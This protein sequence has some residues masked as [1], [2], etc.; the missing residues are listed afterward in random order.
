MNILL[1]GRNVPCE[2][3]QRYEEVI[4][5]LPGGGKG[6]L[7]VCVGGRAVS[8]N[9]MV[10]DGVCARVLTY[11]DEEG[12]R[13]YE[14][15]IQFV[16]LAAARRVLPGARVRIEHSF[17]QALFVR[18]PGTTV[19]R[20]LVARLEREMRL[21]VEEDL[22][23]RRIETT[24]KEANEY[25]E[26]TG[27][28]DKLRLLRYRNFDKFRFYE[29]DGMYEYFYGEMAPSTRYVSVFALRCYLP[30][31]L[32]RTPDKDNPGNVAPFRDLPKLMRTFGETGRWNGIL[33][34]EN[35]A[36]INEMI[37]KRR[38]REFIRVN[39][40]LH[41]RSIEKI[42]DQFVESGARLILIAGPSSSGKTTFAH[43]LII[44]LKALGLRPMKL[45]LDDYYLDRKD[46]PVGEDGK[47]DLER[48]DTLDVPLL[49]EHLVKL[50][51]GEAVEA[52][53]F[54]FVTGERSSATHTFCVGPDQ[55]IVIEGIHALNEQLT[56]SVPREMKFKVYISALTMLNLDDHNRI[57][58]TDARLLRRIVRDYQF[59]GTSPEETMAMW[60][61]VRNGEENYI[62]PY[63][64]E[65]D[66]MFNSVLAYELPI[67]KK[68]VYPMLCAVPPESECYT[69]ARRLVKFLNYLRTA[70][71]EDE[72]PINSILREFIGGCCFYR[73]ED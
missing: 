63:Q 51:Q 71:V 13:I 45:S 5:S 23:I 41:E 68:Y 33:K 72:I 25:F 19:T 32:L 8:L 15:T 20:A 66:A 49:D 47:Q 69:L 28:M 34:C 61:S 60:P 30:G 22:P 36:D 59:R 26:K 6:A 67:M 48:L 27:Q 56:E 50:L 54:D 7:G 17:G 2:K 11:F 62:F 38:F 58:T 40:A 44:A 1:N 24:K 14:R 29:L 39:E 64:E 18:L 16:L 46:I 42:A 31:L 12:R 4:R 21:L 55:P 37:E 9:A 70:D 35:A 3:G 65:A 10:E 43:R 73:E 52:P 53:I 57:R